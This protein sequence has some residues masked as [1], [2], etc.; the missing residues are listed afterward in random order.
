MSRDLLRRPRA[1]PKGGTI[2]VVSPS[3]PVYEDRLLSGI[4][5]LERQGFRVVLAP[6]ARDRDGHRAGLDID[7]AADLQAMYLDSSIDAVI[8]ARGG[9]SAIRLWKH[10]DWPALGAAPPK[11]F[12]GYSD[13]TTLHVPFAKRLGIVTFHSPMIVELASRISE[14]ARDWMFRLLQGAGSPGEVPGRASEALVGGAAEGTLCGG[15]LTLVRATLGTPYQ[16]DT[17]GKLVIIE[18]VGGAPRHIER[19]LVQMIEAGVLDRAAGFIVGEATDCDETDELPVRQVWEEILGPLGK[20]C[21]LGFPVGHVAGN[22]ALPLGV[23]ARLNADRGTITLLE[24]AV[25]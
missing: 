9:S 8:C 14:D 15:C 1:L 19:D 12:C 4:E 20:P 10:L 24:Q 7:R 22:L 17:A 16:I 11:I 23:R 6:H 18:D 3:S 25:E 2:G 21:V 13:I 5:W